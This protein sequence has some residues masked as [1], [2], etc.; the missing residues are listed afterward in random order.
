M[1]TAHEDGPD[2]ISGFSDMFA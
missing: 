1:T 2:I